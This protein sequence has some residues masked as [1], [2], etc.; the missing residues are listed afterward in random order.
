[1]HAAHILVFKDDDALGHVM[2]VDTATVVIDVA[3]AERLRR[4]QVNRLVALESDP[5]QHLVEIIEKITRRAQEPEC[6][7][8]PSASPCANRNVI[9]KTR[10]QVQRVSAHH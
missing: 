2:S 1:M 9:R 4:M 10:H 6:R 3:D 8:S 5:G 7:S